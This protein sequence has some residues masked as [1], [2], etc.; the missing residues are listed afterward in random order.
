MASHPNLI[1]SQGDSGTSQ[2]HSCAGVASLISLSG[3]SIQNCNM[4]VMNLQI[5]VRLLQTIFL[6]SDRS[7]NSKEAAPNVCFQLAIFRLCHI[8][9][10][11]RLQIESHQMPQHEHDEASSNIQTFAV[12]AIYIQNIPKTSSHS[13]G[14]IRPMRKT[15]PKPR[16]LTTTPAMSYEETFP[17]EATRKHKNQQNSWT[18]NVFPVHLA[19]LFKPMFGYF[20]LELLDGCLHEFQAACGLSMCRRFGILSVLITSYHRIL[21]R[22][23]CF[24]KLLLH[25]V[26]DFSLTNPISS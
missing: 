17:V 6:Y 11:F 25:V 3:G 1:C 12:T 24:S 10:S 22:I 4:S 15:L 21:Y 16:R 7:V 26:Q 18:T 20:W 19:P 23:L 14:N 8:N 2:F 13:K 5:M 9:S